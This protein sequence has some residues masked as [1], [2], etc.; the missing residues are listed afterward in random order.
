MTNQIKM[1][2]EMTRE[3][4]ETIMKNFETVKGLA[5]TGIENGDE[6]IIKNNTNCFTYFMSTMNQMNNN[7]ITCLTSNV[8]NLSNMWNQTIKDRTT[9]R[10]QTNE[11]IDSM[12]KQFSNIYKETVTPKTQTN[13][14]K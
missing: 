5:K 8:N 4:N 9:V 3:F 10:T 12:F 13:E 14:Q 7:Y 2:N 11:N 6:S 1:W